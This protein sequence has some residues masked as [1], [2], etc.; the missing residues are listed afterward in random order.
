[1][2]GSSVIV[3][4][5]VKCGRRGLVHGGDLR[6]RCWCSS[7]SQ[8][9]E[10]CSDSRV[11]VTFSHFDNR[12]DMF[13]ALPLVSWFSQTSSGAFKARLCGCFSEE[14]TGDG[15]DNCGYKLNAKNR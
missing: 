10:K 1:M 7:G 8:S 6:L 3:I 9:R 5:G 13:Q 15:S 2:V 14:A 11:S 4:A 12:S